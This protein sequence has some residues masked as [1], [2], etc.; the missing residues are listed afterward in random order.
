MNSRAFRPILLTLLVV[1]GL[2]S[3]ASADPPVPVA[4]RWWGGATVSIETWWHGPIVIGCDSSVDGLAEHGLSTRPDS[5]PQAEISSKTGLLTMPL[6]ADSWP[7]RVNQRYQRLPNQGKLTPVNLS[8]VEPRYSY[9]IEIDPAWIMADPKMDRLGLALISVEGV[10][11]LYA[12]DL[13]DAKLSDAGTKVL[14]RPD[15]LVVSVDKSTKQM[16]YLVSH[17]QPR[18]VIPIA[19]TYAAVE[20]ALKQ[21]SSDTE[22]EWESHNTFAITPIEKA[23]GERSK[24]VALSDKP[25]K[26]TGDLA[27]LLAK[28]DASCRASQKVFAPLSAKQMSWQPPNGTHTPRWNVEHLMGRQ[29]GF[30]SEIF[31]AIDPQTFKA[32]NLNPKQM[33]PEYQPAHDDWTGAEEARQMQ[34]AN[35]Y[36]QRFAYLLEGI[37]LDKPAP[38]SRWTLRKLLKQMDRHFTEHTANVVK[39]FELEGWPA[40]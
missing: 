11:V 12:A 8:V 31:A 20:A 6:D 3:S 13:H 1:M 33:P 2:V 28:M 35:A 34:R 18:F 22:I 24:L 27:E 30:F 15:V 23:V 37:D 14:L 32:I 40:E 5:R 4:V 7:L 26:P 21:L 17:L 39:K 29:L 36:V 25:W 9:Q 38:G 16:Q 10:R 19:A